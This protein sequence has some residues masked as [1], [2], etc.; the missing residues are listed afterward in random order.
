MKRVILL[1]LVVCTLLGV[2]ACNPSEITGGQPS[3]SVG[4]PSSENRTYKENMAV[5]VVPVA[6]ELTATGKGI[7]YQASITPS[8][9]FQGAVDSFIQYAKI[10]NVSFVQQPYGEISVTKDGT[11]EK[12]TYRLVSDKNGIALFA[13]D[14]DGINHAFASLLQMMEAGASTSEFYAPE[15]TI[16]DG[17]DTEY[18]GMMVDVSNGWLYD[19]SYIK[20]YIDMCYFYKMSVLHL[21]LSDN[22]SYCIPSDAYPNLNTKETS[23]TKAQIAEIV[24][25]AEAR[26]VEL[27][28][29]IDVPGHSMVFQKAYPRLFRSGVIHLHEDSIN[30]LKTLIGE[31][32][33]LF[34]Y[35]DYIHV[36]GDEAA[37]KNWNCSKCLAYAEKNGFDV[38]VT[39][40]NLLYERFLA[41][42]MNEMANAVKTNGRQP[43]IWEGVRKEA[44]DL[45]AKD[46]IVM[47]WENY[48]QTT[49]DLLE[50]GF[51]V[52][53]CAWTP[54]YVVVPGQKWSTQTIFNWSIYKWGAVH[55]DSPYLNTGLEIEPT[56][57]VLGAQMSAWSGNIL[58][59]YTSIDKGMEDQR[60]LLIER[61]AY[62]AQN[63]WNV[64]KNTNYNDLSKQ[65]QVL[66]ARLYQLIGKAA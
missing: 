60:N 18:R 20:S 64:E 9:D 19:V 33:T 13:S 56:D 7:L 23:Y 40:K 3:L 27:M 12:G 36:G 21:H 53:N 48:Y 47:S 63:T 15:C 32:C 5:S 29:E 22:E 61:I 17:A 66:N 43:V 2:V 58:T 45:L 30:A 52:I 6:K 41:Y 49:P 31:I 37:I 57:A 14:V 26:G 54:L 50:A 8:S 11:V 1:I 25:Y 38:N 16:T 35:S 4:K 59:S 39:D 55:P 44:N 65:V 24:E 46:I 34:P 51:K 42:F 28:P 62:V 10:L